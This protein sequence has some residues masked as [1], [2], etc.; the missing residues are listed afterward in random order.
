V[1]FRLRIYPLST[2]GALPTG[3]LRELVDQARQYRF[4]FSSGR[5]TNRRTFYC[6]RCQ[7]RYVARPVAVKLR[8]KK[9]GGKATRHTAVNP[10][11]RQALLW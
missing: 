5:R 4:E 9:P 7:K 11:K 3:K 1:L 10:G 6:K 2:V 8:G